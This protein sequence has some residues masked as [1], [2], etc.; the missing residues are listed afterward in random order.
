MFHP[1]HTVFN[2]R[3]QMARATLG[4]GQEHILLELILGV[5]KERLKMVKPGRIDII[6]FYSLDYLEVKPLLQKKTTY[7]KKSDQ[8]YLDLSFQSQKKE[9]IT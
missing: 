2:M 3:V 6:Y 5:K 4:I 8:N 9:E 1:T 7:K